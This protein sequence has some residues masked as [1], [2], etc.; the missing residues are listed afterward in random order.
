MNV[1]C[2][3]CGVVCVDCCFLFPCTWVRYRVQAASVGC[4]PAVDPVGPDLGC[5][6]SPSVPEGLC[7]HVRTQA[8]ASR[9]R[10][11][12]AGR[13][14]EASGLFVNRELVRELSKR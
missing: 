10:S 5:G 9:G 11:C 2:M 3:L 14:W 4:R 1:I 7:T 8:P 12:C 6:R 13:G